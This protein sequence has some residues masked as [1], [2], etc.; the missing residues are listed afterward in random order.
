ML[1][2]S[3]STAVSSPLSLCISVFLCANGE[4]ADVAVRFSVVRHF[5]LEAVTFY[6]QALVCFLFR[7][8]NAT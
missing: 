4:S 1:V 7:R 2:H 5:E 8:F 3:Y 6:L